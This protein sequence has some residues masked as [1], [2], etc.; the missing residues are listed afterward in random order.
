MMPGALTEHPGIA[1]SNVPKVEDIWAAQ[2][3]L[4]IQQDIARA[5]AA[6][7]AGSTQGVID[8][9]VKQLLQL[10]I[11]Q[12]AAGAGGR[13][14]AGAMGRMGM[15]EY[16]GMPPGMGGPSGMGMGEP[17]AAAGGAKVSDPAELITSDF[18]TTPTGRQRNGL[19]DVHNF[20]L[21]VDVEAAQLTTLLHELTRGRYVAIHSVNMEPV[22]LKQLQAAGFMYGAK[23]VVRATLTGEML[24]LRKW[25]EPFMPDNV[26]AALGIAPPPPAT[27][28][29]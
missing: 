6:T 22:D 3:G 25:T 19:Y 4:W 26:K 2:L 18:V 11:P 7:N 9:P 23:P 27:P 15:G 29:A 21:V 8:A 13:S 24:Y 10:T 12:V 20:V 5:I 14:P 1:G 17:D 16:P 28:G